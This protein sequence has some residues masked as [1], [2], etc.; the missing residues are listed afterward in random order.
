MLHQQA[1]ALHSGIRF[2]MWLVQSIPRRDGTLLMFRHLRL[3]ATGF[4]AA[5][6]SSPLWAPCS[7]TSSKTTAASSSCLRAPRHLH[8][9]GRCTEFSPITA[10]DTD[11]ILSFAGIYPKGSQCCLHW[12]SAAAQRGASQRSTNKIHGS[13][14]RHD[15]SIL[16]TLSEV[17]CDAQLALCFDL[18][19]LCA[20][21]LQMQ[22]AQSSSHHRQLDRHISINSVVEKP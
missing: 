7:E 22:H 3:A 11:C 8:C 15:D 17:R 10:V 12:E 6:S 2:A 4:S 13:R 14:W 16:N 19:A 21:L 5:N 1:T 9:D 18:F 20:S